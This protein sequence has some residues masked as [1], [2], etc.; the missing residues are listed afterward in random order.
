MGHML[1]GMVL[2]DRDLV[3]LGD[4]FRKLRKGRGWTQ[5]EMAARAGEA[6]SSPSGSSAGAALVRSYAA[7]TE[8]LFLRH[9]SEHGNSA[10][11]SVN[12]CCHPGVWMTDEVTL[13]TRRALAPGEEITIDY[14]MYLD[15]DWDPCRC[16]CD[17][18][19]CR[20]WITSEDWRSPELFKRYGYHFSPFINER[21]WSLPSTGR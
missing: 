5:E 10:D 1:R 12:H 11:D 17:S 16:R 8:D 18:R 2:P 3:V 4:N 13:V 7:I 6:R 9:A 20:T 21:I 14:A 15:A 19:L